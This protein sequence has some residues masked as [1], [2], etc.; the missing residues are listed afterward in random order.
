MAQNRDFR[1]LTTAP[2]TPTSSSVVSMYVNATS[3]IVIQD[4][5]GGQTWIG[6]RMTGS[7]GISAVRTG[8]GGFA[9]LST[10][11]L[12]QVFFTAFT[13]TS[14]QTGMGQPSFFVPFLGSDGLTYGVP[15]YPLK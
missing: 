1:V 10:G 4:V 14:I 12:G 2:T 9:Q 13:G 11:G 8:G 5:A 7:L 3:G 6:G 15:A